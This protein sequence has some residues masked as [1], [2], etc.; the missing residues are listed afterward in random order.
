MN[1]KILVPKQEVRIG[2]INI[3]N[4]EGGEIDLEKLTSNSFNSPLEQLKRLPSKELRRLEEENTTEIEKLSVEA[5]ECQFFFGG[6]KRVFESKKDL[7][8]SIKE[9]KHLIGKKRNLIRKIL[10]QRERKVCWSRGISY[11]IEPVNSPMNRGIFKNYLYEV[12]KG[13]KMIVEIKEFENKF[14]ATDF[15]VKHKCDSPVYN[16]GTLKNR[17]VIALYFSRRIGTINNKKFQPFMDMTDS[18]EE[19]KVL[20]G[21]LSMMKHRGIVYVW[22]R[23]E[24]VPISQLERREFS[25]RDRSKE[26]ISFLLNLKGDAI[27]VGDCSYYRTKEEL[28]ENPHLEKTVELKA[29]GYNMLNYEDNHIV[30]IAR[31]PTLGHIENRCKKLH[32]EYYSFT[33]KEGEE[34]AGIYGLTKNEESFLK[35]NKKPKFGFDESEINELF[36]ILQEIDGRQSQTNIAHDIRNHYQGKYILRKTSNELYFLKIALEDAVYGTEQLTDAVDESIIDEEVYLEVGFET[37]MRDSEALIE[38]RLKKMSDKK[39]KALI[40]VVTG[41]HLRYED[42]EDMGKYLSDELE[43]VD[44]VSHERESKHFKTHRNYYSQT[45]GVLAPNGNPQKTHKRK[46]N[47]PSPDSLRRIRKGNERD[48]IVG[49]YAGISDPEI[50]CEVYPGEGV[51]TPSSPIIKR[52]YPEYPIKDIGFDLTNKE[53]LLESLNNIRGFIPEKEYVF[54]REAIFEYIGEKYSAPQ[55]RVPTFEK[56]EEPNYIEMCNKCPNEGKCFVEKCKRIS[57]KLDEQI[58]E[59]S[60]PEYAKRLGFEYDS[61]EVLYETFEEIEGYIP[62]YDNRRRLPEYK[63]I[64]VELFRRKMERR[65]EER[66]VK[67]PST[68]SSSSSKLDEINFWLKVFDSDNAE[69]QIMQRYGFKDSKKETRQ[70]DFEDEVISLENGLYKVRKNGYEFLAKG[71]IDALDLPSVSFAGIREP[72][73]ETIQFI[74]ETVSD[75]SDEYVIISGL[76]DGCDSITHQTC[77]DNNGITIAVLPCGFNKIKQTSKKLANDILENDGLLISEYEP[78]IP[79]HE[80]KRG[81]TY[82]ERNEILAALSETVVIFEAGKGTKNTFTHAKKMNK[83]ILVQRINTFNNNSFIELGARVYNREWVK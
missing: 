21:I 50:L 39:V 44:R 71:N 54:I 73:E 78:N 12:K 36:D 23:N 26:E 51:I 19:N 35:K 41:L 1:P 25:L 48:V 2:T 43:E 18:H 22:I 10:K 77:L 38:K 64:K 72:T 83:N 5:K 11:E 56:E 68:S 32:E 42:E 8:F 9:E 29:L 76:A 17:D 15:R 61:K 75:L 60:L 3:I 27:K 28:E 45:K 53:A 63:N 82:L 14:G 47:P 16:F 59:K 74:Q 40:D 30:V 52:V 69:E 31:N 57:D 6:E 55:F 20:P 67:H 46:S 33:N 65:E 79:A 34:V 62:R 13:D 37:Y 70:K 24:A 4:S 7:F 80:T 66:G 49:R 58:L 81:W